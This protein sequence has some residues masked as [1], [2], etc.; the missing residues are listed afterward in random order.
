[1]DQ[2]DVDTELVSARELLDSTSGSSRALRA[3]ITGT[4]Y[5]IGTPQP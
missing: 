3:T 5:R 2:H 1:M 4:G